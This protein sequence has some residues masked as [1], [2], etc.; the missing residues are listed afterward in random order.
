MRSV[1]TLGLLGS[2]ISDRMWMVTP[3]AAASSSLTTSH[4]S[5]GPAGGSGVLGLGETVGL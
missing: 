4:G 5:G 2:A 1:G 3:A